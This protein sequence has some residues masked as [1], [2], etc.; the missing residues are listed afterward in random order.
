MYIRRNAAFDAYACTA[1]QRPRCVASKLVLAL[2]Y[3]MHESQYSI[4]SL[5][6]IRFPLLAHHPFV[7]PPT[8]HSPK[9]KAMSAPAPS[10]GECPPVGFHCLLLPFSSPSPPYLPSRS[11]SQ[12]SPSRLGALRAAQPRR[13]AKR[14]HLSSRPLPILHCLAPRRG[15]LSSAGAEAPFGLPTYPCYAQKLA[16][17]HTL[18][19]ALTPRNG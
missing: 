14:V 4:R 16:A 15:S 2:I 17:V 12:H 18:E 10:L 3:V 1:C 13:R 11:F 6:S 7:S 8:K 19:E 9:A 5:V